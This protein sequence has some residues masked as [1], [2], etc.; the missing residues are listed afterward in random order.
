MNNK[1]R[2]LIC[3]IIGLSLFSCKKSDDA[4]IPN[5]LDPANLTK[6]TLDN[7][8]IAE[9]FMVF[10]EN[11]SMPVSANE[12][13]LKTWRRNSATNELELISEEKTAISSAVVASSMQNW[14]RVHSDKKDKIEIEIIICPTPEILAETIDYYTKD[15]FATPFVS[16]AD[17]N[18]G[19]RRWTPKNVD[20]SDRSYVVMFCRHNVF[21]RVFSGLPD[22]SLKESQD[23][24]KA[25]CEEL[26]NRIKS[27]ATVNISYAN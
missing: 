23:M 5:Y 22:G 8:E 11:L 6:I 2:T 27:S 9:G 14:F 26:D 10:F 7:T 20:E 19:E 16:S 15:A 13:V 17:P 21:I 3:L 25:L 12:Q 4:L 18:V 1:M 24:T